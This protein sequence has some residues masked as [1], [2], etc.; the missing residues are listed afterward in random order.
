MKVFDG[1]SGK[2]KGIMAYVAGLYLWH[3]V[4]QK[5][6][7]VGEDVDV[8]HLTSDEIEMLKEKGALVEKT[9]APEVKK[10][11]VAKTFPP[12]EGEG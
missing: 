3:S 6:I 10:A 9:E 2:V 1:L 12:K 4:Q 5:Y 8:S 11:A 7:D